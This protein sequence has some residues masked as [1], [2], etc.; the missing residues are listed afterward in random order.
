[1]SLNKIQVIGRVGKKPEIKAYGNG[2]EMASFSVATTENWRDKTTGEKKSRTE[3]HRVAAF[4][5][6]LVKRVRFCI[7][8]GTRVFVEGALKTRNWK[9]DGQ[10][11]ER[12][13]TEIVLQGYDCK[14][15]ILDTKEKPDVEDRVGR[16]LRNGQ[17][18]YSQPH[19]CVDASMNEEIQER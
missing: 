19:E 7:D 5:K 14:L 18:V 2:S 11:I 8:Q 9:D 10:N 17:E 1:M 12:S 3:W 15:L 4:Q 6:S 13:I 16:L